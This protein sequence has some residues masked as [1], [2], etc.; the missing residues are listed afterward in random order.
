MNGVDAGAGVGASAGAI[1]GIVGGM[2]LGGVG[3]LSSSLWSLALSK[4][5]TALKVSAICGGM[6][7]ERAAV[8]LV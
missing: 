2:A 3:A 7:H 8:P 1:V 5:H 6:S 4:C